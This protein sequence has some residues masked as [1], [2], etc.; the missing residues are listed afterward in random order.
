MKLKKKNNIEDRIKNVLS[1]VFGISTMEIDDNSSPNSIKSW[2]SLKH[3]NMIVALEEEF[4]IEFSDNE[5]LDMMNYKMIR[6]ITTS[7]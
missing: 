1:A 2:D 4:E 7:K 6:E 5:I 3:M